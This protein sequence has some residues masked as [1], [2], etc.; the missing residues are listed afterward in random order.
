MLLRCAGNAPEALT[1]FLTQSLCFFP[2]HFYS[3]NESWDF[4]GLCS[5]FPHPSPGLVQPQVTML[6]I[7]CTPPPSAGHRVLPPGCRDI[8]FIPPRWRRDR[9]RMSQ[10]WWRY[11]RSCGMIARNGW[12][13]LLFCYGSACRR[14]AS[15]VPTG[16]DRC[17][18]VAPGSP[19]RPGVS[20]FVCVLKS[21][22]SSP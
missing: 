14:R 7:P 2:T 20:C 11:T 17:A 18:V 15:T 10:C 1:C 5:P 21:T 8:F 16:V 9:E 13:G 22:N 19:A 6:L 3:L 4:F 12:V